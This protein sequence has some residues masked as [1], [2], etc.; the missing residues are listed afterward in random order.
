MV[1]TRRGCVRNDSEAHETVTGLH[2][3]RIAECNLATPCR[4]RFT[5]IS[6]T[7]VRS[8]FYRIYTVDKWD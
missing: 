8:R 7:H 2:Y 3:R 1:V 6:H 4:L 5:V